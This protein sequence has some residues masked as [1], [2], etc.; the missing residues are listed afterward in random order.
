MHKPH[1]KLIIKIKLKIQ[2]CNFNNINLVLYSLFI[3]TFFFNVIF[4]DNYYKIIDQ[5]T[6]FNNCFKNLLY[7][8]MKQINKKENKDGDKY[9]WIVMFSFCLNS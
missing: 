6:N 2:A 3:F 9:K 4:T 5:Y 1:N 7:F 8:N